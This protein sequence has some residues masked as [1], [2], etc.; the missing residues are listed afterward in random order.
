MFTPLF[1]VSS[2]STVKEV[3]RDSGIEA[4]GEADQEESEIEISPSTVEKMSQ[5]E[6]ETKKQV[7]EPHSIQ[8]GVVEIVD[9]NKGQEEEREEELE[10]GQDEKKRWSF[11][12]LLEEFD[13]M[14]TD[15]D[16]V[17]LEDIFSDER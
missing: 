14:T 1:I 16:P 15:K 17:E 10:D 7:E 4:S 12:P 3:V 9:A 6:H 2:F 8:N 13:L 11:P 5:V